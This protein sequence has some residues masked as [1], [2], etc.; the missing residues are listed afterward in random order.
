MGYLPPP[1]AR[2]TRQRAALARHQGRKRPPGR[3]YCGPG[4][5][6]QSRPRSSPGQ[7]A[8]EENNP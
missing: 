5:A 3:A 8:D 2:K 1:R 6:G 4:G 7:G